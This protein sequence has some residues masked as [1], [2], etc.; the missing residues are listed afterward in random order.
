MERSP[1]QTLAVV[2]LSLI[3]TCWAQQEALGTNGGLIGDTLL[4]FNDN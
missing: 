2:S 1:R 3:S 4:D